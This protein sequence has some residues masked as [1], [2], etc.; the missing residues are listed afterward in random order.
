VNITHSTDPAR[1]SAL[2]DDWRALFAAANEPSPFLSWEWL[3]AWWS[4]FGSGRRPWLIEARDGGG[5][6]VG[7]L[8]LCAQR[9]G[10][11]G[12]RRY[13]LLGNGV[14]GAD[15][16]DALAAGPGAAGVRAALARALVA[17]DRWDLL[18]LEDLPCGAT[19]AAV[20]LAE[21][22]RRGAVA[23]VQRRFACPGFA[24]AGSAEAHLRGI[25]RRDTYGRRVRWLARQPGFRVEVASPDQA[26]PAMDDLLRL[27]RLRWE[28][29]GGS[30][31]IPPGAVET[32]HRALAPRLAA[33]GWLRLYRLFVGGEAI[34]AVYGLEL[35]RRFYYYQSG[36][37]PVWSA[38]SPGVVLVGRTVEDAY[39]R[40]LTDYDFLRGEEAYKL[41]WAAD[42]R[43]T[44]AVRVRARSLRAG[45][46]T[47]A[48][49]VWRA[50]RGVAR[51][52]APAGVWARLR[53]ARRRAEWGGREKPGTGTASASASASGT[54]SASTASASGTASA[55]ASGAGS[56]SA[57]AS[58]SGGARPRDAVVQDQGP[59]AGASSHA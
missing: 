52:I 12:V 9:S 8:A 49:E 5:R 16:L 39:A 55:S 13:G 29:E 35:G 27:H 26:G 7:L 36:Y 56:A 43:E 46:E 25:R 54:A 42:R 18:D 20:V 14:G 37:D 11:P 58:A 57:S 3:D 48:E 10:L 45:A 21:A 34:A 2:R 32:F 50:G 44:C 59:S 6:L 22:R 1:I 15:G 30:Y 28:A 51:A 33:R 38:R 47:A 24:V 53:L 4:A 41:D 19:L 31:G 17:S 40:G 23:E